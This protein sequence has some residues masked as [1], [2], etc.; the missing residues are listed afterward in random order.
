MMP[1]SPT[2]LPKEKGARIHVPSPSGR[3]RVR[4]DF[5][6]HILIQQRQIYML[7]LGALKFQLDVGAKCPDSKKSCRNC[8]KFLAD[9]L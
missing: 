2:L 7:N 1:S 4:A 9:N 6:I 5:A 3:A 8:I